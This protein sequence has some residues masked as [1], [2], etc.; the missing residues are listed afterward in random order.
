MTHSIL[1]LATLA[2]TAG[3]SACLDLA[4]MPALEP[5]ASRCVSASCTMYHVDPSFGTR[6]LKGDT[7]TFRVWSE[8]RYRPSNWTAE[9]AVRIAYGDTLL[10]SSPRPDSIAVVRGMTRGGGVVRVR[11]AAWADLEQTATMTV[12][13][14][15]EVRDIDVG[16]NFTTLRPGDSTYIWA[17]LRDGVS[18]VRGRPSAWSLSDSTRG[19]VVRHVVQMPYGL[20]FVNTVFR[21]GQDTGLVYVR[22]HFLS[23]RDSVAVRIQR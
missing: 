21:A 15:A 17:L 9:G 19:Q 13:D 5:D 7:L 10:P 3:S 4:L 1:R 22:A 6:F 23:L 16:A 8:E 11:S 12:V 20:P 2:A 18:P 14:S